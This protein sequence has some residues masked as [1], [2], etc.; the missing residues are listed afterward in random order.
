MNNFWW[1]HATI[2][3]WGRHGLLWCFDPFSW[4]L[5]YTLVCMF[6]PSFARSF[7]CLSAQL[8]V[9]W[10]VGSFIRL[11]ERRLFYSYIDSSFEKKIFGYFLSQTAFLQLSHPVNPKLK[12]FAT[13]QPREGPGHCWSQARITVG[14]RRTLNRE[15]QINRHCKMTFLFL[16]W[17]IPLKILIKRR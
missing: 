5:V 1:L 6:V 17:R 8:L 15:I 7:L 3:S 2:K 4:S 11:F 10:L 12:R 14:G 16:D 9:G 13:S